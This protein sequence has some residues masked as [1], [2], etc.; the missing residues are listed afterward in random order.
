VRAKCESVVIR[1]GSSAISV[2]VDHRGPDT[3]GQMLG[4]PVP[5]ASGLSRE[6]DNY[7]SHVSASG[8][9]TA[10]SPGVRRRDADLRLTYRVV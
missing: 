7:G 9:E 1:I 4:R 10:G 5:T 8:A 3:A 2:R 6:R